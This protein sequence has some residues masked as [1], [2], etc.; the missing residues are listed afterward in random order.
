MWPLPMLALEQRNDTR[1]QKI[2][3]SSAGKCFQAN[4]SQVGKGVFNTFCRMTISV[5]NQNQN[6]NHGLN[7]GKNVF[8]GMVKIS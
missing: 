5:Q 2:R 4:D 8:I 7:S 3:I 6:Q 1:L